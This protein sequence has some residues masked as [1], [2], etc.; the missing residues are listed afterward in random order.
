[1]IKRILVPTDFSQLSLGAIDYAIDLARP[2]QAEIVIVFVIEPIQY[3]FPPLLIKQREKEYA[4]KLARMAAKVIKR[5][6]TVRT[7]LHFGVAYQVI[8]GLARKIRADMIVMSTHGRSALHNLLIGSVAERVI[9]RAPCPVL[10]VPP[11]KRAKPKTQK[12]PQAG[13]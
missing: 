13:A 4:D 3:A 9:H 8:V 5:Y 6:P 10:I 11:L 7:E 1:M 2:D 12:L